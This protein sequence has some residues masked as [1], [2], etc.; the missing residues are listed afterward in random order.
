MMDRIL[1]TF[2]AVSL[3]LLVWLYARS[4]DQEILDNVPL[5]VQVGM[6]PSQAEHYNLE[7]NGA[8]QVVVSFSGPPVRIRELRGLLQRNE[9]HVAATVTVPEDRLAESRYADTI[10]IESNDIHAPPGVTPIVA[11]GRNRIP[12]TLHRLVERRLPVRFDHAQAEPAHAVVLEPSTVLVRGPQELLDRTKF[13]ST[14]SSEMP[15]R[16]ANA[17][18]DAAAVSRVPLV[19]EL[20]GRP[21]RVTPNKVTVRVPAQPRK[22]YELADVPIQFLCP[23]NFAFRPR[24]ANERAGQITL[25]VQGP[26]LDEPPKVHVYIDLTRGRFTTGNNHE[27]LQ[28]QLPKDIQLA[29]EAPRSVA[30]DL[31]P[32]DASPKRDGSPP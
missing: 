3:A 11:D 29:Q 5:Q 2:V 15:V 28:I 22:I 21:V 19:L 8:S 27:P 20:E 12:V 14:Q 9:L 18:P 32:A 31:Q 23:S 7:L 24:F 25:R 13:I 30:F 26:I 10:V 4:R 16:Q 1:S 6:A 17:P